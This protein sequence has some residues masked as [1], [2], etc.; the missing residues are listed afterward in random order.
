MEALT[1]EV[2]SS[3][4][5]GFLPRIACKFPSVLDAIGAPASLIFGG[6]LTL[7]PGTEQKINHFKKS[8]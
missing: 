7:L 3:L 8:Q 4:V 5:L 6:F 2:V 1:A